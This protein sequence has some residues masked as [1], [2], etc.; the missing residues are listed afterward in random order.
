VSDE[1]S[2]REKGGD[3]EKKANGKRAD[4]KMKKKN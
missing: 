4:R 1:R 3:V 2:K